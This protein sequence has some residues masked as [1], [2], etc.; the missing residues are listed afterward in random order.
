MDR[1]KP[2]NPVERVSVAVGLR[3]R[4]DT[5]FFEIVPSLAGAHHTFEFRGKRIEIQL[6]SR[7]RFKDWSAHD[8]SIG[9]NSYSVRGKRQ[10]PAKFIVRNIEAFISS[11]V[12]RSVRSDALGTVN[13]TLYS[14]RERASLDRQVQK[15]EALLEAAFNYWLD[16]LRWKSANA[17]LCQYL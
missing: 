1:I 9:C 14:K 8:A 11:G 15:L 3:K 6:P 5:T 10:L 13:H 12:S 2:R 17:R 7:P 16:I 4:I